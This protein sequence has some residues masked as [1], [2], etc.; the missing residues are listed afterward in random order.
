MKKK[1]IFS[2]LFLCWSFIAA[3]SVRADPVTVVGYLE[4]PQPG[5][6]QSGIGLLSGW[7][8]NVSNVTIKIDGDQIYSAAYGTIREDTRSVCNGDKNGFGFLFNYNRLVDGRHTIT[9]YADGRQFAEVTFTVVTFGH[10]FLLGAPERDYTIPE[11]PRPGCYAVVRWQENQQNFVIKKV[12]CDCDSDTLIV[13]PS[14]GVLWPPNGQMVPVSVS[15]VCGGT[16]LSCEI[17]DVSSNEDITGDRE[18]EDF[19]WSAYPYHHTVKL[20]ARRAGNGSGR[21]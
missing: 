13:S 15:K 10:E 3:E 19:Y 12:E 16:I 17:I 1:V 9:A 11:F 7:V 18:F 21:S 5:S 4:N 14:S 2:V 20:R 8:C 6:F